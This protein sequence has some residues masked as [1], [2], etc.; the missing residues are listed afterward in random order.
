M[1]DDD[2]LNLIE[3][4]LR[5]ALGLHDEGES[6]RQARARIKNHVKLYESQSNAAGR[7]PCC[8]DFGKRMLYYG[9]QPRVAFDASPLD[10][11]E[12]ASKCRFCGIVFA[13]LQQFE[14]E[15]GKITD[16]VNW[17]YAKRTGAPSHMTLMLEI[18][19]KDPRPKLE[20]EIYAGSYAGVLVSK[21][22]MNPV[23]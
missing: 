16:D 21:P 5:G 4:Q 3:E 20:L 23:H 12:S 22:E 10:L 8:N 19:F 9:L 2:H 14:P 6:R 15:I 1:D 7:C 18:Y 13:A 11:Q 17:I